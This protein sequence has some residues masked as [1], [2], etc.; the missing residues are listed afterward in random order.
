[1][2]LLLG[3]LLL[4]LIPPARAQESHPPPTAHKFPYVGATLGVHDRLGRVPGRKFLDFDGKPMDA[5]KFLALNGFNAVR[6]GSVCYG[7][8]LKTASVDN[9]DVDH[10][11]LNF[12]LDWGGVDRQVDTACRARALGEKVVLTIQFGQ[13]WVPGSWHESI[14][15]DMLG[16]DYGQ[17]LD[18]IDATTRVLLDQF[19]DAGIQPDVVIVENEA[20]SGMLFQYVGADGKM[21][22]RDRPDRD[23]FSDSATGIYS[24]LPKYVGYFKQ[25]ILSAKSELKKRGFDPAQTRFALHTTT[26]YS[27]ARSTFDR[28]FNNP[29]ADAE[30]VYYGSGDKPLG[31]VTAVPADLRNVRL[32]DLV[33]VMGFSFYPSLP[34]NGTPAGFAAALAGENGGMDLTGDLAYFNTVIPKYGRYASGP[35][36]GQSRKQVLV[37]EYATGA[38]SEPGFDVPRQD[39]FT[40]AFFNALAKYEWT[41]G[42]LW[43]EPTYAH[44]NWYGHSGSLYREG[45]WDPALKDV[46]LFRPIDTIKTW[47]AFAAPRAGTSYPGRN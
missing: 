1:M 8:P 13:D 4:P 31:I 30:S 7:Q 29:H 36:K 20:D 45:V 39:A 38:G 6:V 5:V 32:A 11:E 37:V 17:T 44:N 10:R 40:V 26:N 47:G 28:V 14:P 15:K 43:W 3:A 35:F 9:A 33:D 27:R 46:P 23:V 21:A 25:E 24:I 42:A 34:R 2:A 19:L 22:I 12:G 41:M 18:K 16:L